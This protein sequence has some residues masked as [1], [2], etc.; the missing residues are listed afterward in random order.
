MREAGPETRFEMRRNAL[1]VLRKICKSVMLCDEQQIRHELMQDGMRLAEFA[2]SML[3]W[4][5][6]DEEGE[7]DSTRRRAFEKLVS[8]K[9]S[10]TRLIWRD[11]R[12]FWGI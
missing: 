7:G 2:E 10:V 1:E 11:W 12:M 9:G 3:N 8:R 6:D 4:H 5:R